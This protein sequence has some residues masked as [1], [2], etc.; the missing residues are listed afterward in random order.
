MKKPLLFKLEPLLFSVLFVLLNSCS[1]QHFV[2]MT[3]Q[4]EAAEWHQ[5]LT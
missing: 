4:E 1:A 5:G 3:D 2:S